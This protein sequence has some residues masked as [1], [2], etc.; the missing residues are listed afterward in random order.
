MT[1]KEFITKLPERVNQE[2]L[3]GHITCFH[4][5]IIGDGGGHYTV[6]VEEGEMRVIESLEGAPKCRVTSSDVDFMAVINKELNPLMALMTGKI[7]ITNQGEMLKY[8]KI[9]GIM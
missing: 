5:E 1:A 2:A 4:F 7:K 9:F 3:E 6:L 8:A